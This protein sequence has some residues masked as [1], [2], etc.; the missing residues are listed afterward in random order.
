MIESDDSESLAISMKFECSAEEG[1]PGVDT[2]SSSGTCSATFLAR[3]RGAGRFVAGL[4]A[5][6]DALCFFFVFF[7]FAGAPVLK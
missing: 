2:M 1:G 3:F 5:S 6:A 4:V 7:G